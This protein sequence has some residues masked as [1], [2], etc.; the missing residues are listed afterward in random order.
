[1]VP[2]LCMYP[3]YSTE[4]AQP[5]IFAIGWALYTAWIAEGKRADLLIGHSLGEIIAA[6]AAG[7][8]DLRTG[9]EIVAKRGKLMQACPRQ[10]GI[11]CA[12]LRY[13][14][15]GDGGE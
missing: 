2:I 9:L 12:K 14:C 10:S 8:Y 13:K 3:N 1:M 7:V 5:A 15:F 6:C 4:Y 11:M